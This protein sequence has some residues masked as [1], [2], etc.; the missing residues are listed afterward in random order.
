MITTAKAITTTATMEKATA[1]PMT[2]GFLSS[3]TVG[4]LGELGER[5]VTL[6][7]FLKVAGRVASGAIR[8]ALSCARSLVCTVNVT[9]TMYVDCSRLRLALLESNV[10]LVTRSSPTPS[11]S[12]MACLMLDVNS[13]ALLF[14]LTLITSLMFTVLEVTPA[15][16]GGEAAAGGRA[17]MG[18]RVLSTQLL[19]TTH[20]VPVVPA[21]HVAVLPVPV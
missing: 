12:A 14:G 18:G 6:Q 2:A 1:K 10:T 17:T 16:G 11:A 15:A 8:N 9:I 3:V 4:E 20:A 13:V 7:A 19:V 5:V 21:A